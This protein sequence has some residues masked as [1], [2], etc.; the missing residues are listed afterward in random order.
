M[1]SDTIQHGLRAGACVL[2]VAIVEAT[3]HELTPACRKGKPWCAD[4]QKSLMWSGITT[5]VT[6]LADVGSTAEKAFNR[7][8]GTVVGGAAGLAAA[9][10]VQLNDG[11]AALYF[12]LLAAAGAAGIRAWGDASGRA[13][14]GVLGAVTFVMILFNGYYSG[15]KVWLVALTRMGGI[16]FGVLVAMVVS[17][18]VF[19]RSLS[20]RVLRDVEVAAAA[21]A[22]QNDHLWASILSTR[23]FDKA[24]RDGFKAAFNADESRTRLRSI[25]ATA[26]RAALLEHRVGRS[27]WCPKPLSVFGAAGPSLDAEATDALAFSMAR[28]DQLLDACFLVVSD[29]LTDDALLMLHRHHRVD[30]AGGASALVHLREDTRRVLG[31]IAAS[32]KAPYDAVPGGLGDLVYAT[33]TTLLNRLEVEETGDG[34][35]RLPRRVTNS[36]GEHRRFRLRWDTFLVLYGDL[37]KELRVLA[38]L[39]DDWILSLPGTVRPSAPAAPA[40]TSPRADTTA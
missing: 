20:A 5:L 18:V 33:T 6:T 15:T 13:Y 19:P 36:D 1:V 39:A 4:V 10:V 21:L 28:V 12:V 22:A 9:A 38:A 35:D 25:R 16:L 23:G 32:L 34:E 8:V 17:N 7:S 30:A 26:K 24:A 27:W 31:G 40:A 14:A 29:T 11:T 37:A 2:V 3:L